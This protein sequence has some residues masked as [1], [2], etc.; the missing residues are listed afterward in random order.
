M[1]ELGVILTIL[2]LLAIATAVIL[3]ERRRAR[4]IE[5]DLAAQARRT[6]EMRAVERER[7]AR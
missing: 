7:R 3:F 1:T 6:E 2:M 5:R 4:A